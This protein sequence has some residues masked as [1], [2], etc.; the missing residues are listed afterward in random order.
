MRMT[1]SRSRLGLVLLAGTL[2]VPAT[3]AA[4]AQA[5]SSRSHVV[6]PGDTLWSLAARYLG[7]G[8]RWREILELNRGVIRS[9]T[10]L[11][12]G[13]TLRIPPAG[14]SARPRSTTP[15]AA[16]VALPPA[17]RPSPPGAVS[18]A[19]PV[20]RKEPPRQ[21]PPA[22]EP[23][24]TP[25]E[26]RA[27]G[28]T[29]R[30]SSRA[31]NDSVATSVPVPRSDPGIR[32]VNPPE[33]T[34]FF[35]RGGSNVDVDSSP[36]PSPG[37]STP[38]APP[39]AYEVLSVPFVV[40]ADQL[41]RAGSCVSLAG[42]GAVS[43]GADGGALLRAKMTL[44]PPRGVAFAGGDRL[45][46]V[47]VGEGLSGLG[48]VVIPTGVVLGTGAGTTRQGEIVAQF[49][50][51]SCSDRLILPPAAAP[52]L[53]QATS[54]VTNGSKGRVVWV[55]SDALLPTLQHTL[56]V[57]I[58]SGGGAKPGDQ[59]SVTDGAGSV[60]ATAAIVRVDTR[61]SSALIT[62]RPQAAIVAGLTA[63]ITARVP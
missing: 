26:R 59:I 18:E 33:R 29:M 28:L 7:N 20:V 11:P 3:I 31:G 24:P 40:G 17:Q 44:A 52:P 16:P 35:G 63:R 19:P 32:V 1:I 12:S 49:D 2:L 54:P 50:P 9:E 53:G 23:P 25:P 27:A 34:I 15:P 39:G 60:V 4:Q 57:D 61:T 30:D 21:A 36:V 38:V 51:I 6:R 42:A 5:D 56:I 46:L 13:A 58:G 45:V 14:T 41:A 62:S 47:R 8:H 55:D 37:D 43:G 10:V 22:R 48:R